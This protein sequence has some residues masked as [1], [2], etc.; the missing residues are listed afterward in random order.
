MVLLLMGRS[1]S[2]LGAGG[3]LGVRARGRPFR[4]AADAHLGRRAVALRVVVASPLGPGFFD[5]GLI[6]V[7]AGVRIVS[8]RRYGPRHLQ[9]GATACNAESMVTHLLRDID[10]RMSADAGEL[11]AWVGIERLE[12]VRQLNSCHTFAIE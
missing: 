5:H 8:Q 10:G 11:I 6:R 7:V 4:Y 9:S 2:L 1:F 12:V 3:G